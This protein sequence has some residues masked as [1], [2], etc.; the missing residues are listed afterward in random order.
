MGLGQHAVTLLAV[1]LEA[2]GEAVDRDRLMDA[3]W[4]GAIV[5]EANLTVQMG[6]L[7][8]ALGAA[9][10]GQDWIVTLPR[11]GYR[12]RMDEPLPM[13]QEQLRRRGV[14]VLP[15]ENISRDPE[16]SYFADGLVADITTALSRVRSL[17]VV[18]RN[19]AFAYRGRAVDVRLVGTELGVDYVLEGSVRRAGER[20]RVAAQLIDAKTGAHVWARNFGGM[21]A[22]VFDMQDAIVEQV[23]FV[24]E[25]QIRRAEIEKAKAKRPESLDVY[26]LWVLAQ[27]EYYAGGRAMTEQAYAH[28][29]R[30]LVIDPNYGPALAR[31][32][33]I[34]NG[35]ESWGW[36][37]LTDMERGICID[38]ARRAIAV[39]SDDG[40]TMAICAMVLIEAGRQYD[41]G[42]EVMANALAANP[43]SRGVCVS[44]SYAEMKCG[45]LDRALA[46]GRRA[47]AMG[48]VGDGY[49]P[50]ALLAVARV[51]MALGNYT[52]AL[53]LGEQ[54]MALNPGFEFAYWIVVSNQALLGR[55]EEARRGLAVLQEISPGL[56]LA[57]LRIGQ[58]SKLPERAAAMLE[59]L[60][61]AGLPEG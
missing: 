14:V 49:T 50:A 20:L 4:R 40:P 10:D 19:S 41:L 27:A 35:R 30:A 56:T 22:D 51:E 46:H 26:E 48:S 23:A 55:I 3:A 45:G 60:R 31:A 29:Q 7:R 43:Y 34:L 36:G 39:S 6:A 18:A 1:L 24:I 8:K 37:R 28:L 15:F 47:V 9:P 12:L 54:A 16:Q 11:Y 2:K 61:L 42:L 57:N 5:E 44:A 32:A 13:P 38:L 52:E 33:Q 53:R 59:G 58:A 17:A 25:P 21:G